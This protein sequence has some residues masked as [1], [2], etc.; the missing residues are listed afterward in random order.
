MW[1]LVKENAIIWW[2]SL[3]QQFSILYKFIFPFYY[4]VNLLN[5]VINFIF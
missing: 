3:L 2:Y 4:L 5:K 1:R